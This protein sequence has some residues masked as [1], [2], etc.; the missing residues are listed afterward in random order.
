[1]R[2]RLEYRLPSIE[3]KDSEW[4][5]T[6]LVYP[7]RDTDE[8]QD[9]KGKDYVDILF[10]AKR[11]ARLE[12]PLISTLYER[13]TLKHYQQKPLETI[14][15]ARMV[16]TYPLALHPDISHEVDDHLIKFVI[17]LIAYQGKSALILEQKLMLAKALSLKIGLARAQSSLGET[18]GA[19]FDQ[20]RQHFE[21]EVKKF[22]WPQ[23]IQT[24]R[25]LI[26][27]LNQEVTDRNTL[28]KYCYDLFN[29]SRYIATDFS[30]LSNEIYQCRKTMRLWLAEDQL[31][32][33]KIHA[34][35]AKWLSLCERWYTEHGFAAYCNEITP[36]I[37]ISYPERTPWRDCNDDIAIS[38]GG[39][40]WHLIDFIMGVSHGYKL[41]GQSAIG[42]QV[43]PH[44]L[45][46]KH[47][48]AVVSAE[49]MSR[50]FDYAFR[51]VA[52]RVAGQPARIA[53][54]IPAKYVDKANNGY[55]G[56]LRYEMLPLLTDIYLINVDTGQVYT[57]ANFE[58]LKNVAVKLLADPNYKQPEDECHV[59]RLPFY[60]TT[61]VWYD[62]KAYITD[63]YAPIVK[64]QNKSDSTEQDA[65]VS[66]TSPSSAPVVKPEVV[67]HTAQ[68]NPTLSAASQASDNVPQRANSQHANTPNVSFN[69]ASHG[70]FNMATRG[71]SVGPIGDSSPQHTTRRLVTGNDDRDQVRQVIKTQLSNGDFKK[72]YTAMWKKSKYT[73]MS[74]KAAKLFS[75]YASKKKKAL[76]PKR[77][78]RKLAL[79]LKLFCRSNPTDRVIL[80][81]LY[82]LARKKKI[83]NSGSFG[84]RLHF[85]IHQIEQK[86]DPNYLV[87]V[88]V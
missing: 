4:L 27:T 52:S 5:A 83:K 14:E 34:L 61:E 37:N 64:E 62:F 35:I 22:V 85:M 36:L 15:A 50:E 82:Q 46:S 28:I 18:L 43:H 26:K 77:H 48:G 79:D 32:F 8:D 63:T 58:E 60:E 33:P 51:R 31:D 23:G 7:E 87:S 17:K 56:G 78:H 3:L 53:G 67:H 9:C 13:F 80:E 73:A 86:Q 24:E 1:M 20:V 71:Q 41:E 88:S 6:Y 81:K 45:D 29:G 10:S 69:T 25:E 72:S 76:H 30:E 70:I 49:M 12:L 38:H 47:R 84:K 16:C 65:N 40:F 55:E 19:Y 59:G 42:V 21:S 44:T 54:V 75:D 11:P 2:Q 66:T 68:A 74:E 39:D 57:A